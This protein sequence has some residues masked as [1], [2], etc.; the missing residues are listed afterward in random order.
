MFFPALI[1]LPWD[2]EQWPCV[3]ACVNCTQMTAFKQSIQNTLYMCSIEA[4][5]VVVV[6]VVEEAVEEAVQKQ[7]DC[8]SDPILGSRSTAR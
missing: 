3:Q 1:H 4:L 2:V 6:V 5:V 7:L 8:C